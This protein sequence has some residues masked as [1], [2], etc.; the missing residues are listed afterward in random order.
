VEGQCGSLGELADNLERIRTELERHSDLHLSQVKGMMASHSTQ[1]AKLKGE[2]KDCAGK[3]SANQ[4]G[5]Q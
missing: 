4:R 1:L 3:D 2:M 5:D